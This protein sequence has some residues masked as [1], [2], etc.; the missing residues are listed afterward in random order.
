M[1]HWLK[2]VFV[3]TLIIIVLAA[4]AAL[5]EEEATR[6]V[7]V[8]GGETAV[9][10]TTLPDTPTPTATPVTPSR[11]PVPTDVPLL[12]LFATVT[13]T[14][15]PTSTPWP[16][17]TPD[18]QLISVVKLSG[19]TIHLTNQFPGYR[20]EWSPADNEFVYIVEGEKVLMH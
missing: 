9:S 2:A 8:D 16:S 14:P 7:V 4:C 15:E 12:T 13:R 11:T 6:E 1:K 18:L 3:I 19:A 20:V 17:A 5:D 10:P